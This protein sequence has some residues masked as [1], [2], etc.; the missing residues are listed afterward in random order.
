MRGDW[1][2]LFYNQLAIGFFVKPILVLLCSFQGANVVC[3]VS[4][5]ISCVGLCS[6]RVS[7]W[8]GE[9]SHRKKADKQAGRSVSIRLSS[10]PHGV[11]T[12]YPPARIFAQ[13]LP[14][15]N[16]DWMSWLNFDSWTSWKIQS[17]Q[18]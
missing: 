11:S 17:F 1:F 18:D 12:L 3:M 6:S 9:I 7:W 13:S 5:F 4:K 14:S 16:V 10:S 15:A 2:F 8:K